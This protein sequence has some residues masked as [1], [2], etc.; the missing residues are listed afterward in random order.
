MQNFILM[1]ALDF[2]ANADNIFFISNHVVSL[3]THISSIA[4]MVLGITHK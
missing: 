1:F 2:S 3:S 4:Q